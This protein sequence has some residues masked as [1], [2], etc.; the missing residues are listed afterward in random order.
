MI[1]P[2]NSIKNCSSWQSSEKKNYIT[3][4]RA[5]NMLATCIAIL[6]V[7]FHVFPREF[8]KTE[9]FG[10]GLMDLGSVIFIISSAISSRGARRKEDLFGTFSASTD[11]HLLEPYKSSCPR[12]PREP[13]S[14]DVMNSTDL[15]LVHVKNVI[16]KVVSYFWQSLIVLL[17]GF[18][19]LLVLQTISY[20][21]HDSE[22]GTHWNFFVTLSSIWFIADCIKFICYFL[23]FCHKSSEP[24]FNLL[25]HS[26]LHYGVISVALL[27]YSSYQYWLVT[28][29][30][31]LTD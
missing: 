20:P 3:N 11:T 23:F 16:N 24:R 28:P 15:K 1:K 31:N 21:S 7:D 6:A 19:R 4:F 14:D 27:L 26:N 10:I 29:H 5:A 18:G 25:N 30:Y 17:L 9:T 8:A 22:Y 13:I 12:A 2:K